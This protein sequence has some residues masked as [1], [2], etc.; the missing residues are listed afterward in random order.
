MSHEFQKFSPQKGNNFLSAK[1]ESVNRGPLNVAEHFL[2]RAVINN[3]LIY[4]DPDLLSRVGKLYN[5][6]VQ[7]IR[8]DKVL[9]KIPVS[10]YDNSR[11]KKEARKILLKDDKLDQF[12]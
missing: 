1:D 6:A 7:V 2:L 9:A 5:D 4:K 3:L 12:A 11:I 8:S 10:S